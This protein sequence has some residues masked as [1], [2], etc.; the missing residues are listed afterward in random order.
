MLHKIH[1][2]VKDIVA[3]F[4]YLNLKVKEK[5]VEVLFEMCEVI[6]SKLKEFFHFETN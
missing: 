1:K 6:I 5:D 3:T 4:H 2:L